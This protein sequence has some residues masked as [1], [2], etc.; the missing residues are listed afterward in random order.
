MF[1][2][3]DSQTLSD[4]VYGNGLFVAI[5]DNEGPADEWG[6]ATSHN[7]VVLTSHNVTDWTATEVGGTSV[8]HEE[9]GYYDSDPNNPRVWLSSV[10]YWTSPNES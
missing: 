3:G 5:G 9:G 1:N 6:N 10:T 4:I 2:T 7:A 8:L